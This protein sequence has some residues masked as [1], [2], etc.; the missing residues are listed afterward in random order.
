MPKSASFNVAPSLAENGFAVVEGVVGDSQLAAL[1]E[2]LENAQV[3]GRLARDGQ[4]YAIRN[5]LQIEAVADLARSPMIRRLIKPHLGPNCFAVRGILFDKIPEANWKVAWH[6]D[7]TIELQE[8]IEVD[9]FGP[10]SIKAGIHH[11]QPPVAILKQ[12]LAVRI[13]LDDCGPENGPL[14]VIPK[15]HR[16]GRLTI[17]Q[18][19]ALRDQHSEGFLPVHQGDVILM[20]PLLAH[21]SSSAQLPTRRRVIHLEFTGCNLPGGLRWIK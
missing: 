4:S 11:V 9:G 16:L 10:W 12:M 6:Q 1:A 17:D 3:D 20:R 5:L 7:L 13:H 15:S 2:S 21:A 18:M 8:Q 19:L 14:R